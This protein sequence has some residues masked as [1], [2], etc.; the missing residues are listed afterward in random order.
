MALPWEVISENVL[1]VASILNDLLDTSNEKNV[2]WITI[3]PDG[4]VDAKK[5]PNLARLVTKVVNDVGAGYPKRIPNDGD[6]LSPNVIYITKDDAEKTYKLP[7][8]LTE[9]AMVIVMDGEYNAQNYPQTIDGNGKKINDGDKLVC[10]V[11]GFYVVLL[12]SATNDNWYTV[13]VNPNQ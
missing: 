4:T 13:N 3:N 1:N 12:Y 11:N 6:V 9:D 8:D 7:N 2:D 10:D 5:V